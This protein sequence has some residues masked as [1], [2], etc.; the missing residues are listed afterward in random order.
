MDRSPGCVASPGDECAGL[1]TGG[2]LAGGRNRKSDRHTGGMACSLF[3]AGK[4]THRPAAARPANNSG[5]NYSLEHD[6]KTFSSGS[7]EARSAERFDDPADLFSGWQGSV[8]GS[9]VAGSL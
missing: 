8:Y 7:G 9:A 1:A 6:R 5:W 2:E 4:Q 3:T